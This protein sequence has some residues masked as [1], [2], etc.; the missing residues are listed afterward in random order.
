MLTHIHI[1]PA[2]GAPLVALDEVEAVAGAGLRGDRNF[3]RE[4]QVSLV[5]SGE[6]AQAAAAMGWQSIIPGSTRRNLTVDLPALPRETG[7]VIEIGEV[8]LE[9]RRD[10][11][12]CETMESAVGPG[13]KAALAGRAGVT[14]R[15]VQGGILRL[16][17][18]VVVE[19]RAPASD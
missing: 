13:A 7:T 6:L 1:A 3:G 18:Q 8:V 15:V 2:H 5:C 4:R 9:V 17:D 10:C 19:P 11:A 16:G 12:P 14:A